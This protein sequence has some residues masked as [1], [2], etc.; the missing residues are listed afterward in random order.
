MK[1]SLAFVLALLLGHAPVALAGG[2]ILQTGQRIVT[3]QTL[4]TSAPSAVGLLE[5][6]K[7]QRP[8]GG[9][10]AAL[11]G[12]TTLAQTG[13]RTRTKVLI[14]LGI[15]AAFTA[16]ALVIDGGVEDSTPSSLGQ[17]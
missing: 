16:A 10:R 2:T 15:A 6:K 8:A 14:G 5:A 3:R 12:P 7:F 11:Q 13:M 4:A 9:E 1:R 17:R